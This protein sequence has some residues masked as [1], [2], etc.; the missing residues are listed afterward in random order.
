MSLDAEARIFPPPLLSNPE[1][2]V[3]FIGNQPSQC[4]SLQSRIILHSPRSPQMPMFDLSCIDAVVSRPLTTSPLHFFS[5]LT[6]S[7]LVLDRGLSNLPQERPNP[8]TKV[9]T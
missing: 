5:F 2:S 4:Q 9:V 1:L 3:G 6:P 8:V 7:S